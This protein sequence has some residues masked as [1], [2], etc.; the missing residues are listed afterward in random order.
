MSDSWMNK[1]IAGALSIMM[2]NA[3][4]MDPYAEEVVNLKTTESG[5]HQVSYADLMAA[6]VDITDEPIARVAIT[7]NGS[8]VQIVVTGSDAD[9]SLFGAGSVIRFVAESVD[10][11]YSDTNVYTLHLDSELAERAVEDDRVAPSGAPATAYLAK[12]RF[13]PQSQYSFASPDVNDPWYAKRIVASGQ[14]ASETMQVKL[15]DYAPGG[16]SGATKAKLKVNLWGGS[17]LTG[18]S[19][20]HHVKVKFN[21]TEVVDGSFDGLEEKQ[22]DVTLENV[23]EGNNDVQVSLPLDT[24]YAFDV[25]NVNEVEVSYPRQFKAL[26][27]RLTFSSAFTKFR[28]PGFSLN[29]M[30]DQD[31]VVIMRKDSNGMAVQTNPQLVCRST[32]TVQLGG[33]GQLA[34]YFVSSVSAL[35]PAVIDPLP[36]EQDITSGQAAYL[37]ISHPDFIGSAGNNL[38][39]GLASNMASEFGSAK[40]VDVDAIY[41]Q[42]GHHVFSPSAIKDYIRYA[43][44]NMGTQ[45][46]VLVG[47]DV[48]DYR[49]FENEDA[50]SFIPSI[51]AAT[52]N[53]ISFA[54]VDAKYVDLDDDNVPD[55]PIGRLPVRT[56]AQLQSLLNKRAS[57]QARTYQGKVL[58]VADDF[59]DAQQYDFSADADEVEADYLQNFSVSKV[60]LDQ[61][62]SATQARAQV[63]AAINAGQT[64]TAFFGHSSTNQWSFN[65]L[66][67]GND[68]ANLSNTNKPTVVTQWG[69][70]NAYYVSPNEDSMGHR[71]MMEGD[72]GAVAVMGASTL[73]NADAERRL[74]RL[75]FERL[76]NGE[77][78]GEAVTNAKQDYAQDNPNDLDVLL[79]WTLLGLPDLTVN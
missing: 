13:A 29:S 28:I 54:P 11:L 38:L 53:D 57:Y 73:T 60:Y 16:N 56:V 22:F 1:L 52:G 41:A 79:G 68:A 49:Q 5:I 78:L 66:F 7:N 33:T 77:R 37:I 6:E 45:Y 21:R 59:D 36:L 8:P 43:V 2:S 35:H 15:Q 18:I 64:L 65:G 25:V 71:F 74:A 12:A 24:G 14:G 20:D 75:V 19:D 42:F 10:T 26:D 34:E 58:L 3:H 47:G 32:C 76:A 62:G 72:Q 30:S 48:Y 63:T 23:Q 67:T 31:D 70:W 4:A 39:E 55:L 61:T 46:V 50:T 9:P 51:Y 27:D 69:C 40:V 17:N 44:N